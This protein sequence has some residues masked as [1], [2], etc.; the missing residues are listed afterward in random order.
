MSHR[1]VQMS[2]TWLLVDQ[3][4]DRSWPPSSSIR[5]IDVVAATWNFSG[6][7]WLHATMKMIFCAS[8]PPTRTMQHSSDLTL[9]SRAV[10][11]RHGDN[12]GK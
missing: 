9:I 3:C 8:L 4:N 7:Q 1:D 12:L 2:R 11:F 5:K 10:S 6:Q